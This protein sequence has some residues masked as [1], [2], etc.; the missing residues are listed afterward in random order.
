V[1]SRRAD[2]NRLPLLQLRVITQALQ[3]FT[4]GCKSRISKPFSF[5]RL[6]ACCT[7]LRSRWYQCGI[8]RLPLMHSRS[9]SLT[10]ALS[11]LSASS[12]CEGTPHPWIATFTGIPGMGGCATEEMDEVLGQA[13]YTCSLL[14][15]GGNS[16]RS[17]SETWAG[18]MV[19]FTTPT[20]SSLSASRSVSS[21]SLAEKAS[22][23]FLASYFLL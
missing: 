5:L 2:S 17:H 3:R 19:S 12:E 14:P 22:R 8:K 9:L 15:L 1:E 10:S 11:V 20:R 13:I 16:G 18:C 4:Q 21:L 7:V 23:V 6:T